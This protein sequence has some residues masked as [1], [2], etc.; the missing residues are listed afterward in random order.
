MTTTMR[1]QAPVQ[2]DLFGAVVS[3][4]RQRVVDA[5][6]CLRDAIP[7]ALQIVV[8]LRCWRPGDSRKPR[9]GG[10]WAYCISHAGLGFE[11]AAEWWAGARECGE[12]WGWSRTPANLMPWEELAGLIGDD[13]RRAEIAGWVDTL[14]SIRWRQLQRPHELWP[15]PGGWHTSYFCRDH[16]DEHW[17]ARRRA[18]QLVLDLL[19][20]AITRE[21]S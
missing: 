13:P 9:A 2:L 4:E 20:D 7:E 16:V 10:A 1:A 19:T 15:D 14:P 17:T 21:A 18:W 3:A 5:L 6:T 11:A 12:T 8:E